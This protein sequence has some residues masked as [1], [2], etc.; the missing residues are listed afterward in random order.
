MEPGGIRSAAP[1]HNPRTLQ[2]CMIG[3]AEKLPRNRW[4]RSLPWIGAFLGVAA[5][6]WVLRGFDLERFRNIIV[7]ADV[8]LIAAVPVIVILEQI[9]RAWKW[10]LLLLP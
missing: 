10:R 8:R 2:G 4:D 5:L 1:G 9:V 3:P 6:V 7:K